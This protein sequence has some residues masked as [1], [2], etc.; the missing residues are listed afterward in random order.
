[1][2]SPLRA[3]RKNIENCRPVAGRKLRL[4]LRSWAV[5]IARRYN[6]ERIVLFGSQASG[7][8]NADS[9]VDILVVLPTK[10][11]IRESVRLTLALDPPF[12]LDLIVR[13]P[14]HLRRG[15]EEGDPFLREVIAHGKVL[16]EKNH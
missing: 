16:H 6:P 2:K 15:L 7:R 5:E 11:E 12:P 9:D 13:T 8:A 1:M 14:D 4:A 3:R 10:N